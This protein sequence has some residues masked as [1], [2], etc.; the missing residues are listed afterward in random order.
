MP[1]TS[2]TPPLDHVRRWRVRAAIVTGLCAST[3]AG[4]A[5]QLDKLR[6]PDGFRVELLTDAV[7][8][9]RQMTLGR[10]ADGKGIVYV[11]SASAGKVYAVE[12]GASGHANVRTIASNLRLPT[13]VAWRDGAL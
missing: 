1:R 6:V 2:M 7:P 5:P 8:N 4:A 3:V 13:G 12:Y 11:G 9:A 10:S